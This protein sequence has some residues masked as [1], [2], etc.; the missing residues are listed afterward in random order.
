MKALKY[1]ILFLKWK[2]KGIFRVKHGTDELLILFLIYYNYYADNQPYTM[3]TW[4]NKEIG[5]DTSDSLDWL[6]KKGLVSKQY[7]KH[8]K[9]R[10][11]RYFLL[12]EGIKTCEELMYYLRENV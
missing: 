6:R 4:L 9:T 3:K 5:L 11:V 12:N 8:K 7:I 1:L 10:M 2:E